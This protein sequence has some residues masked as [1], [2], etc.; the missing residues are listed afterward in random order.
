MA[1]AKL[2]GLVDR[3]VD[4]DRRCEEAEGECAGLVKELT[5]LW[6][7]GGVR[8]VFDYSQH[9]TVGPSARGNA[10]SCFLPY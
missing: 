2:P 3:A 7:R 10:V 5:I 6:V 8:V 1:E 4:A 9:M